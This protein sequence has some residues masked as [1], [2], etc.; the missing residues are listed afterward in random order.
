MIPYSPPS[1]LEDCFILSKRIE[2]KKLG[3][4]EMEKDYISGIRSMV[5]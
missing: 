4:P 3:N 5:T 2:G 1:F